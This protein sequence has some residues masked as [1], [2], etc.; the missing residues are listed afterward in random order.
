MHDEL[1][2]TTPSSN[3]DTVV[4]DVHGVGE[5]IVRPLSSGRAL[6]VYQVAPG[7]WLVSEVG[8]ANEGR[9][10]DVGQ[11]L[12]ALAEVEEPA[13]WWRAV[14]RALEDADADGPMERLSLGLPERR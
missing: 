13:Q 8:R 3:D 5:W 6:H 1:P 9:G 10:A 14:P 4:V 11:A 7:D 2:E 12:T